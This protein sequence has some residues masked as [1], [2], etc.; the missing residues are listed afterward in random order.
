MSDLEKEFNILKQ[1]YAAA[2]E[3]V[4]SRGEFI[5]ITKRK[6]AD[7]QQEVNQL[8]KRIERLEIIEQAYEAF[9]K[10]L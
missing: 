2:L 6:N 10:A 4:V 5:L 9:K 8:Q 3:E 7:L 1:K